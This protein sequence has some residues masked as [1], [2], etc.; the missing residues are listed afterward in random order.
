MSPSYNPATVTV[1]LQTLRAYRPCT[2]GWQ[3]TLSFYGSNTHTSV[4]LGDIAVSNGV[5]DCFWALRAFPTDSAFKRY[6]THWVL[7]PVFRRAKTYSISTQTLAA[8]LS[9]DEASQKI[10]A[11]VDKL[12]SE[13]MYNVHE[14]E[15]PT[16]ESSAFLY[17]EKAAYLAMDAAVKLDTLKG[18]VSDKILPTATLLETR[19]KETESQ[20][21]DIISAFPP[22][23]LAQPPQKRTN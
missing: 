20:K 16:R 14:Y 10:C 4:S 23:F 1:S 15:S 6:F 18:K 3:R 7:D 13:I 19:T 12:Y 22:Q 2:Q 17:A 9:T 21:N 5:V 11:G 8:T